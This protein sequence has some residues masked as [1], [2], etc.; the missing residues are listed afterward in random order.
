MSVRESHGGERIG[1]EPGVDPR[2]ASADMQYGHIHRQCGIEI[3]D[4]SSLRTNVTR[5][6]NSEF[7][8]L[9]DD[10]IKSQ[11]PSWVR[12]RWINIGGVSWDVIKG[13]S[14]RYGMRVGFVLKFQQLIPRS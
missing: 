7:I 10:G 9:M 4:Y 6:T 13:M 14:L 8:E 3:T 1:A 5:L 12:V 11:R 2:R